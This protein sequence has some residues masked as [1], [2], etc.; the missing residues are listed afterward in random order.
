MSTSVRRQGQRRHAGREAQ[1]EPSD[2][3][4]DRVRD[5]QRVGEQEQRQGRQEQQQEL[6]LLVCAEP[7]HRGI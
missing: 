5:A 3:E 1:H 7:A 6:K 2:D 4:Q